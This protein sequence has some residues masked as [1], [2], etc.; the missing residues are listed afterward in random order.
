M[1]LPTTP[2][3]T[4]F[5]SS[6]SPVPNQPQRMSLVQMHPSAMDARRRT[7]REAKEQAPYAGPTFTPEYLA[8]WNDV[9]IDDTDYYFRLRQAE[10]ERRNEEEARLLRARKRARARKGSRARRLQIKLQLSNLRSSSDIPADILSTPRSSESSTVST[11]SSPL[12]ATPA[13][14]EGVERVPPCDRVHFP[15]TSPGYTPPKPVAHRI[16]ART[17]LAEGSY[18]VPPSP[19]AQRADSYS[20]PKRRMGSNRLLS[21]I[22]KKPSHSPT[23]RQDVRHD[24]AP[25]PVSRKRLAPLKPYNPFVRPRAESLSSIIE[26]RKST[27]D[28]ASGRTTSLGIR[29]ATSSTPVD[30]TPYRRLVVV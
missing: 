4:R 20:Y 16:I 21:D 22:L 30:P 28:H 9:D 24:S 3:R 25:P 29:R 12:P 8:G 26:D 1:Q 19:S 2:V 14:S 17:H 18:S 23:S 7:I 11:A 13:T 15:C 10:E 5:T 27:I 6:P